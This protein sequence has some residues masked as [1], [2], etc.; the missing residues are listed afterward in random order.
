MS[1]NEKNPEKEEKQTEPLI[2]KKRIDKVKKLVD[3]ANKE[4]NDEAIAELYDDRDDDRY[5]KAIAKLHDD[6]FR[7][8]TTFIDQFR[9]KGQNPLSKRVCLRKTSPTTPDFENQV[10]SLGHTWA[11]ITLTDNTGLEK[12]KFDADFGSLDKYSDLDVNVLSTDTDVIK[13]WIAFLKV[14]KK[15]GTTFSAYWDS[16]FYFEPAILE[17]NGTLVSRPKHVLEDKKLKNT[18]VPNRENIVFAMDTIVT[19]VEAY[20]KGEGITLEREEDKGQ[21]FIVYPNPTSKN[22]GHKEEIQQYNAMEYFGNK[23]L[24]KKGGGLTMER[25]MKFGCTKSEGFLSIMSLA[26]S[27]VFGKHMENSLRTLKYG[28]VDDT[29][30]RLITALEMLYNLKMHVKTE[31]NKEYIKTKYMKRLND[32]LLKSEFTCIK[33]KQIQTRARDMRLIMKSSLDENAKII[34]TQTI[35]S[36]QETINLLILD[37]LNGTL[38]PNNTVIN[39]D[40][41]IDDID[42]NIVKIKAAIEERG[43]GTIDK[44]NEESKSHNGLRQSTINILLN[45]GKVES[46]LQS[47]AFYHQ[48]V[49]L[50]DSERA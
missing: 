47:T 12:C 8:W 10:V 4:A 32:T 3:E 18:L 34:K 2:W 46:D 36:V 15:K 19:Y 44:T 20:M 45:R 5:D 22:F 39:I 9:Q 41:N 42:D 17:E 37:E 31:D 21:S 27:G 23:C 25:Y 13:S 48:F 43:R 14:E 30:W 33:K 11:Q 28:F 7:R 1:E 38:C 40:D 24:F 35:K 50:V 49:N 6:R 29:S 16:N 26:I